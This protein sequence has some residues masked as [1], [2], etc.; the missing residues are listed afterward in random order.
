[1][2]YT[3]S[4]DYF[5][6]LGPLNNAPTQINWN[7]FKVTIRYVQGKNNF[8]LRCDPEKM[9]RSSGIEA[10]NDTDFSGNLIDHNSTTGSLIMNKYQFIAL[11]S[12]K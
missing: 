8:D 3:R 2:Y 4:S 5:G 10:I 9:G 11:R 12:V 1:M 7:I 6:N